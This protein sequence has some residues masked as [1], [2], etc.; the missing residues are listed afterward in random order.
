MHG[1]G[2]LWTSIDAAYHV[3]VLFSLECHLGKS[4]LA[5][6]CALRSVFDVEKYG[7]VVRHRSGHVGRNLVTLG[8]APHEFYGLVDVEEMV[9]VDAGG[10]VAVRYVDEGLCELEPAKSSL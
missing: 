5:N 2:F 7:A 4:A 1:Y 6:V 8:K 10:Q 9:V 3:L